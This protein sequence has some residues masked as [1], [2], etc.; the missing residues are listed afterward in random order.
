MMTC[1]GALAFADIVGTNYFVVKPADAGAWTFGARSDDGF[2]LRICGQTWQK[3]YG[4]GL[5]DHAD[6]SVLTFEYGTGNSDTRG[7]ISLAAGTY[8]VTPYDTWQGLWLDPFT[9]ACGEGACTV[10]LRAVS[11]WAS[12]SRARARIAMTR[13]GSISRARRAMA[14]SV[15]HGRSEGTDIPL[16]GKRA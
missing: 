15:P 7:V 16:G 5:I 12:S 4:L 9:V 2:A 11:N 14:M 8:A 13:K 1:L 10:A 3:A 6:R